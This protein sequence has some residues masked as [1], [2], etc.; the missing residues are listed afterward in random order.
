M[1]RVFSVEFAPL[2]LEDD[3]TPGSTKYIQ[4]VAT[5]YRPLPGVNDQY[6]VSEHKLDLSG[7]VLD[8]LT[9]YFRNSFEQRGGTTE[10]QWDVDDPANPLVPFDATVIEMTLLSTVPLTDDN[11]KVA[12]LGAPG[13]IKYGGAF[14]F[15]NFNRTHIIHGTTLVWNLDTSFGTASLSLP[16]AA[17]CRVIQD[18]DFSSLEPTAADCIYCYRIIYLDEA[19][20]RI[21]NLSGLTV[22]SIPAKRVLLNAM[23]DKEAELEYLFRLKRSYELANQV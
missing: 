20:D 11:L 9:V 23:T 12:A 3:P 15:G 18:Q 8:D 5:D 21:S 6:W 10:L 19:Y 2:S 1:D 7:Y 13:F 17:Y 22:V 4:T 16:G 14:D